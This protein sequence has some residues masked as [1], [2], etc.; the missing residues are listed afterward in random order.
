VCTASNCVCPAGQ[1][2]CGGTCYDSNDDPAHCGV[3]CAACGAGQYCT[4]G[5]C[6]DLCT[7][8]DCGSGVCTD[9]TSDTSHCGNSCTACTGGRVCTASNCVCPN[10]EQL[11][12][13]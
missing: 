12:G 8:H 1:N 7:L 6:T 5:A 13:G 9:V 3:G 10:S 4:A 11:C 2:L